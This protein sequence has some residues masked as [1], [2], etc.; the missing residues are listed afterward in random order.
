MS[1]ISRSASS[2]ICFF[3]SSYSRSCCRDSSCDCV[4][5]SNKY[6]QKSTFNYSRILY[7]QEHDWILLR[8]LPRQNDVKRKVVLIGNVFNKMCGLLSST[9]IH[10]LNSYWTNREI[11]N[12]LQ[13]TVLC[14]SKKM[15][16]QQEYNIVR[17]AACII[18]GIRWLKINRQQF[19]VYSKARMSGEDQWWC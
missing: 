1:R 7:S 17:S 4:G 14:L 16:I 2:S 5:K 13:T 10:C 19:K 8:K 9:W 18:R 6:H 11:W 15:I 12:C 3:V